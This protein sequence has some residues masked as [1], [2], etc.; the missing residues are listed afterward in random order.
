MRPDGHRRSD[1]S[2][3]TG[4]ALALTLVGYPVAGLIGSAFNWNSTAASVPFRIGVLVLSAVLWAR[5]PPAIALVRQSPWLAGFTMVYLLRLL[6]DFG[7]TNV[8]GAGEAL[9]FYFV[10]VLLPIIPIALSAAHLRERQTAQAIALVAGLACAMAVAMYVMDWGLDRSLTEVTQRLSFEAV[11]P[12]TLGHAAVTAIIA[13]LALGRHRLVGQRL[14]LIA[15][16]IAVALPCL[17][18]SASR[19][20]FLTLGLCGAAYLFAAFSWRA[21]M[22]LG[23]GFLGLALLAATALNESQLLLRFSDLE[24]DESAM[25]R[26]LL[27]ANAI[28]QFLGSP[29]FGSA[30]AELEFSTYP[31]NLF[32][33]TGMATGLVG[34]LLMGMVIYHSG[35]QV[36]R[37]LRAGETLMPLLWL[38]YFLAFQFSGSLWGAS[39][40]WSMSAVLL[41]LQ[42]QAAQRRRRRT[43]RRRSITP[44]PQVSA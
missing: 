26:L 29:L 10:T 18:L 8:P 5:S 34:L 2:S 37:R 20:P 14:L 17:L 40:F 30:F 13:A 16:V 27:Q 22:L 6:W 12:I 33:E 24:E 44:Q 3:A 32:I 4:W 7:V 19:G 36:V 31:H 1:L 9:G 39:G 42:R 15:A 35:V 21:R 11:N 38:Q 23:V 28:Q 43:R 41:G 25:E